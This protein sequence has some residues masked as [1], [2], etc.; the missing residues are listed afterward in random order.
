MNLG[1]SHANLSQYEDAAK[2]YVKALH[3]SPEAKHIWGYLRVVLSC[4]ERYDLV[5]L[6]GKEDSL[7]EIARALGVEDV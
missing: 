5:Q 7:Y 1:I 4:M 6:S 3:L 2:A